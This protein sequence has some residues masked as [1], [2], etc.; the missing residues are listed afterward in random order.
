MTRRLALFKGLESCIVDARARGII[1]DVVESA[2][3]GHLKTVMRND[4]T[5]ARWMQPHAPGKRP[6]V[7]ALRNLPRCLQGVTDTLYSIA[8]PGHVFPGTRFR[9]HGLRILFF[10]AEQ[11]D[12]VELVV[13]FDFGDHYWSCRMRGTVPNG[14]YYLVDKGGKR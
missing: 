9:D 10:I 6:K 14:V 8:V 5:L 2:V 3:L 4:E 1:D 11:A 7:E 13:L 12:G